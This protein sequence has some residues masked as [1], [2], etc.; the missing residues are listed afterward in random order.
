MSENGQESRG[1]SGEDFV[2]HINT[3][4]VGFFFFILLQTYLH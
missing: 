3:T 1:M 2:S 4:G